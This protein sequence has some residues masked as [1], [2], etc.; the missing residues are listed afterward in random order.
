VQGKNYKAM[1]EDDPSETIPAGT[2]V[3]VV[4]ADGDI[5]YVRPQQQPGP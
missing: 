2:E 1:N 4:D 3:D 5:A